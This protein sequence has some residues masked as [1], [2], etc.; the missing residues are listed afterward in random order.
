MIPDADAEQLQAVR[1]EVSEIR[2]LSETPQQ[3]GVSPGFIAADT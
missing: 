3:Q 2:L 1:N